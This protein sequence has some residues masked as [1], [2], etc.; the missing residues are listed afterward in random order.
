MYGLNE[1]DI[2]TIIEILRKAPEVESA[3]LFGSRA[4]G[5]FKRGS[6]VDLA[7]QGN[8]ANTQ[9]ASA[10]SGVLN[11]DTLMPYRFDVISYTDLDHKD[12]AAH[13]DRVDK[14]IYR[15]ASYADA[16]LIN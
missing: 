16:P 2:E 10:I 11:E 14:V 9:I 12:L 13:I 7:I 3:V 1:K 5:N 15:K 4:K 8:L 6:D